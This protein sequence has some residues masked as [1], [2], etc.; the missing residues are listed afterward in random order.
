MALFLVAWHLQVG[1]YER[2][3]LVIHCTSE[4]GTN[5]ETINILYA[6]TKG[7]TVLQT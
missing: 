2:L 3:K 5:L 1:I 7:A 6:K 4:W